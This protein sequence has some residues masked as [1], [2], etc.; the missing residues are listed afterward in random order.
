ML[1]KTGKKLSDAKV[2]KRSKFQSG[3]EK[4]CKIGQAFQNFLRF[5]WRTYRNNRKRRRFQFPPSF[6]EI[7]RML[8]GTIRVES[9]QETGME[10]K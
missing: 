1:I 9:Q 3:V 6:M 5:V 2:W 4:K 7:S 8:L 10:D